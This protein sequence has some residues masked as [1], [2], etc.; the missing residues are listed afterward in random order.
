MDSLM[1]RLTYLILMMLST[2]VFA[3]TLALKEGHPQSYEVKKGD[4]LWDISAYFLDDPWKWPRLW[5][6]NPQIANPHLIYPGDMLTLVFI[7]GQPRLVKK[8]LVRRSP[9]GRVI[10][11]NSAI[12]M[13]DLAS[14]QSYILQN[15]VENELWLEQQPQVMGGERESRHH[16]T[17]DIIYVDARLPMGQ[18][19][20]MY[21]EGRIFHIDDEE[22]EGHDRELILA[23]SGRVVESGDV[24]KVELLSNLRETKAGYKV[25]AIEDE[26]LMSAFYMPTA[27]TL[28]QPA[29]VLAIADGK[30]EAGHLD[31]IYFDRGSKA[32]VKAGQV[33]ELYLDGE[34]IAIDN[35]GKPVQASDRSLYDKL[36]GSTFADRQVKMPD[37]YRGN[38]LVFKTFNHQSMGLIMLNE[39][40][41]RVGDKLVIPD[42]LVLE[43]E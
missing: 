43:I 25:L 28:S 10:N 6:A 27:A 7:N 4:T 37:I 29:H 16:T 9:Q 31:V 34:E 19:L 32:G 39:R 21:E 2:S 17:G 40:P 20:G 1:K 13:V 3:D 42:S 18:K 33:L 35:D 22:I 23:S 8:P 12:P 15:R 41:V 14:I 26:A 24:S 5:G 38:I 36:I 30:R 11:K